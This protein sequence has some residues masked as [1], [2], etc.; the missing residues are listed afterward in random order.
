MP[1]HRCRDQR[2]CWCTSADLDVA[3]IDGEWLITNMV[4]ASTILTLRAV[5]G[6][7]SSHVRPSMRGAARSARSDPVVR[8]VGRLPA[9]VHTKLLIA[10]VGTS[11]LL[12]AVGLLGQR[13]LGQSNDRVASLGRLQQR[14]FAYVQLQR[15]AWH[16]RALLAENVGNAF[17]HVWRGGIRAIRGRAP[18][19][20]PG[21]GERGR[22]DPPR[23][24]DRLG[25]VPPPGDQVTLDRIGLDADRLAAQM[26]EIIDFDPRAVRRSR[27]V[28]AG[29]QPLRVRAERLAGNLYQRAAEL[30][31][32]HGEEIDD[33]IARNAS[34]FERSR[35]LFIGVAAAALVLALVLGYVLSGS[36]AG[37]SRASTGG[38]QRSRRATSPVTSRSRTATSS[39]LSP[40]T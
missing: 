29:M 28:P 18:S 19:G 17:D 32:R 21:H 9:K 33:L 31:E 15:D 3:R 14:A 2:R 26:Q 22:P 25:F 4:G 12:V 27:R 36:L 16:V 30:G 39:A 5:S 13:V 7:H 38:S 24:P 11:L 1:L 37:R 10:F 6:T 40:R 23:P 20:G 8:A 35:N 34:S